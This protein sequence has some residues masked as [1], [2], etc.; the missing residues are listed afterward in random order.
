MFQSNG[1]PLVVN[2]DTPGQPGRL[3]V[4]R[5]I[6]DGVAVI[7]TPYRFRVGERLELTLLSPL[8]GA[9][10]LLGEVLQSWQY[11]ERCAPLFS[12]M[13]EVQLEPGQ[14]PPLPDAV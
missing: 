6:A 2:I 1:R 12:H 11:G 10:V 8:E 9:R 7:A 13:I 4:C 5:K 14:R 3:G